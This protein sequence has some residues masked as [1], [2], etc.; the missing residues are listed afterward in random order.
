MG[1]GRSSEG[2]HI[3]GGAIKVFILGEFLVCKNN[4]LNTKL[5]T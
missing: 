2:L 4:I 5:D 1:M 3:G